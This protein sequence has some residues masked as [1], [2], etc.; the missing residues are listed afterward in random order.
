MALLAAAGLG[1]KA[2]PALP[3]SPHQP[4]PQSPHARPYPQQLNPPCPRRPGP[5][6]PRRQQRDQLLA[7]L[8]HQPRL[9]APRPRQLRR[10][11][12]H[13]GK[14][15]ARGLRRLRHPF[16]S[17]QPGGRAAAHLHVVQPHAAQEPVVSRLRPRGA[18]ASGHAA[19]AGAGVGERPGGVSPA[20]WPLP[21]VHVRT[22]LH[23]APGPAGSDHHRPPPGPGAFT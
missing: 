21:C 11:L 22:P 6:T 10:L 1:Q 9:E 16:G 3:A 23:A 4:Y 14:R 2:P 8:A 17:A 5:R 7:R 20:R 19:R 13:C 15:P 12:I 18:G